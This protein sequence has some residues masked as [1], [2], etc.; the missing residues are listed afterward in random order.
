MD[1]V[2]GAKLIRDEANPD[3]FIDQ[4]I[5]GRYRI[6]SKLATGCTGTVY[7]AQINTGSRVA[8][9]V[10]QNEY[11]KDKAYV[12]EFQQHMLAVAAL[13]EH[14]SN[15]VRVFDCAQAEDGRLFI[16]MEYLEGRLL[17]DILRQEGALDI[18][19]ALFLAEQMAEGLSAAHAA[20][21]VHTDIR[22]ENFMIVGSIE[23][24]KILGFEG[25][26]VG[27]VGAMDSLLCSGGIPRSPEYLAPEQIEGKEITRQTDIYSLGVVLH[28]ML[29]GLLP[30]RAS[31]SDAALAMHL[32]E[33]PIPLKVLCP[34]IPAVLEAKVLQAL[35][36]EPDRRE[37]YA[38]DV[39]N[40]S[41]C[42][43]VLGELQ[44]KPAQEEAG[45]ISRTRGTL[46][47]AIGW[48]RGMSVK[49]AEQMEAAGKLAS[50]S[51]IQPAVGEGGSPATRP[52][53]V[54]PGLTLAAMI[55]LLI[56]V[57]APPLW[58]VFARRTPEAP[59]PP[60]VQQNAPSLPKNPG[61]ARGPEPASAPRQDPEAAADPGT[62]MTSDPEKNAQE[63]APLP[64]QQKTAPETRPIRSESQPT[65]KPVEKK[66]PAARRQRRARTLQESR[67]L[68]PALKEAPDTRAPATKTESPSPTPDP[69][70]VIDWLLQHR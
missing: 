44:E 28:Q 1:G 67:I 13:S 52:Q 30:F 43:L 4:L 9:K 20:G 16:A 21:I 59:P 62:A 15:I 37:S 46:Q 53:R 14:H 69:S 7:L 8:V 68:S 38:N 24:V 40:Q 61:A 51:R 57:T 47:A 35:E 25:A 12:K 45:L 63:I 50:A 55:G 33:G 22:P 10:L 49:D 32:R 54:G 3:P 42:E 17:S 27:G 66:P 41:L 64:S 58:M 65:K 56:L 23:A 60:S 39:I 29:T 18:E 6:I 48:S 5:Q 26:K 31:M 36:K 34:G 11:A 2:D 19:R 70:E